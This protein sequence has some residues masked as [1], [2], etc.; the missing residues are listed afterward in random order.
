M[1]KTL[2]LTYPAKAKFLLLLLIKE[3][4]NLIVKVYLVYY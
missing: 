3:K 1:G 4:T 2:M